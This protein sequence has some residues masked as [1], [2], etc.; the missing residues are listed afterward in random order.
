MKSEYPRVKV[1]NKE[2][3]IKYLKCL[4]ED[5]TMLKN[6]DW[7]P[8]DDSVEASLDVVEGLLNYMEEVR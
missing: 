3:A 5:F 1:S 8:D 2:E 4:Q 7:V 6:G